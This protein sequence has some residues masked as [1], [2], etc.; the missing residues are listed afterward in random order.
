MKMM[1]LMDYTNAV[2]SICFCSTCR[3][4]LLRS[5]IIQTL[6]NPGSKHDHPSLI[7]FKTHD[8]H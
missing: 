3:E 2:V 6:N 7:A 5:G 4:P 1:H 8:T